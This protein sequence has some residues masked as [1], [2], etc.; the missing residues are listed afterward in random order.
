M[1]DEQAIK[2]LAKTNKEISKKAIKAL[3]EIL[4]FTVGDSV[5][6]YE[7]YNGHVYGGSRTSHGTISRIGFSTAGINVTIREVSKWTK[8]FMLG[9]QAFLTK[10]ACDLKLEYD[11]AQYEK[12]K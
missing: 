9:K 12:I 3:K 2:A 7:T 6:Y 8:T 1:I 5:W 10:E 11:R 4:G